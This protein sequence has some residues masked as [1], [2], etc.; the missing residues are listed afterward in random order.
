MGWHKKWGRLTSYDDCCPG[1][2]EPIDQELVAKA[3]DM[4]RYS[5]LEEMTATLTCPHCMDTIEVTA[6][7]SFQMRGPEQWLEPNGYTP[8]SESQ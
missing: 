5:A 4:Q 8:A 2:R 1:C 6:I 7:I 3:F